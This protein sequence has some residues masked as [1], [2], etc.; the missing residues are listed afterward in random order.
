MTRSLQIFLGTAFAASLA[1]AGCK[2]KEETA[3]PNPDEATPAVA[4]QEMSGTES[5]TDLSP[6]TAQARIDDVTLGHAVAADHSIAADQSGDDFAPGE[7]VHL[8]MKV[9][10]TPAGSAV[11]VVWL[12]PGDARIGDETK[13]VATGEAYLEFEKDT[14][15]WAKGDYKVEV[16]LGD[17][18]VNTENFQ[19]VDAKNAGK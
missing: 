17:E 13:T 15:G 1:L 2:G 5:Q 18:K 14:K 6:M 19:I 3:Q 11:K 10:D 12:G 16:W 7:T 4:E 9:G 8:A